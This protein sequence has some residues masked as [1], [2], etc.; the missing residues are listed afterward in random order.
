[1]CFFKDPNVCIAD[2]KL[3]HYFSFFSYSAM[4]LTLLIIDITLLYSL[5]MYIRYVCCCS[6]RISFWITVLFYLIIS[7]LVFNSISVNT[8]IRN[9]QYKFILVC[10]LILIVFV[11]FWFTTCHILNHDIM[12]K[13][14]YESPWGNTLFWKIKR[15]EVA[16][17][18]SD[19]IFILVLLLFVRG[20]TSVFMFG[21]GFWNL[22][23][24][25]TEPSL[26]LINICCD[27]VFS[28]RS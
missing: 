23:S 10:F 20:L 4:V 8:F 22:L 1:M 14:C 6:L 7:Y 5:C 27:L 19:A 13:D 28:R 16:V 9:S 24:S 15:P 3:T 2:I 26:A 25:E 12:L 21:P 17:V 18:S 11:I